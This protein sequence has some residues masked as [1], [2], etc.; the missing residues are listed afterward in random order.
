[1]SEQ[2]KINLEELLNN[3][4]RVNPLVDIFKYQR[5]LKKAMLEFG[6]QL[7][8][9]AAENVQNDTQI[10]SNEIALVVKYNKKSILDTIK[11]IE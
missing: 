11:Q 7:L 5:E 2:K 4:I 1:M 10:Y 6:K 9:L 3:N 8:E